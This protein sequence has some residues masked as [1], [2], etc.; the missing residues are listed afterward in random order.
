MQ[1]LDVELDED[2]TEEGISQLAELRIRNLLCFKEL[3]SFNDSGNFLLE[4]P[5]VSHY[6]LREELQRM[7]SGN[8]ERFLDEFY[9]TKGNVARYRSYLNK[10]KSGKHEKERWQDQLKKH[11][12]REAIM[13]ELLTERNN[14]QN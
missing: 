8:P 6:S 12:E 7:L 4:H 11:V 13:K 9:K 14:E 2:P 5:L 10:K 1:Q 3:Q